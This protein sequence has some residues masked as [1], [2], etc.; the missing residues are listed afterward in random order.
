MELVINDKNI[1]YE[2]LLKNAGLCKDKEEQGD[3]CSK[4]YYSFVD[5]QYE[6]ALEASKN[7]K[8]MK[9]WKEFDQIH[10]K[11][12]GDE[13]YFVPKMHTEIIRLMHKN[14]KFATGLYHEQFR[15]PSTVNKVVHYCWK[16]AYRLYSTPKA[17]RKSKNNVKYNR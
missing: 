17:M 8:N 1:D 10:I 2:T 5:E 6:M 9:V 13:F 4:D 11:V 3:N 15:K 7:Y 14:S 12:L 16:H